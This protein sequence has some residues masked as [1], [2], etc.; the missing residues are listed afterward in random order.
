MK[1]YNLYIG[2]SQESFFEKYSGIFQPKGIFSRPL[3]VVVGNDYLG[4]WLKFKV[5]R[6]SGICANIDF[7]SP[8][9]AIRTI[10]G[11]VP[12]LKNACDLSRF[13]FKDELVYL[14]YNKLKN[15]LNKTIS[16]EK[17]A[18]FSLIL[19]YIRGDEKEKQA[20]TDNGKS[21]LDRL[22][23]TSKN[24]GYL[25]Y[26]YGQNYPNL[27]EKWKNN[28][29]CTQDADD[30][31]GENW[32]KHLW[33]SIYLKDGRYST[34]SDILQGVRSAGL[35]EA[36]LP[37][38]C[39]YGTAFLSVNQMNF[40]YEIS[41]FAGVE[42][43][44]LDTVGLINEKKG[45][46]RE[47]NTDNIFDLRSSL[48]K[49]PLDHLKYIYKNFTDSSG[50]LDIN[51]IKC[52]KNNFPDTILGRLQSSII[53]PSAN[54]A[55]SCINFGA[56]KK[57]GLN[58]AAAIV[59][60]SMATDKTIGFFSCTGK[61]RE[62][63]VLKNQILQMLDNDK[64]LWL[65]EIAIMAPDIQEY[66]DLLETTF[67]KGSDGYNLPLN[68]I[69]LKYEGESPFFQ[70]VEALLELAGR[71]FQRDEIFT[72]LS[73]PCVA[74]KFS[75]TKN[76]LQFWLEGIS[77]LN[78]KW[79]M[80]D[81]HREELKKGRGNQAGFEQGFERILSGMA[82]LNEKNTEIFS[83]NSKTILPHTDHEKGHGKQWGRFIYILRSLYSDIYP[84]AKVRLPVCRW[85]LLLEHIIN[86]YIKE[87][88]D[89]L[90]DQG[91]RKLLENFFSNI[92][93]MVKKSKNKDQ[94]VDFYTMRSLVF[95]QLG[96]QAGKRGKFLTDGIC[97]SSIKSS[98]N[99]PFKV[100]CLLGMNEGSFPRGKSYSSFDLTRYLESHPDELTTSP[101]NSDRFSIMEIIF[102]AAE[103]LQ[104]YYTG[105]DNIKNEILQPSIIVTEIKKYIDFCGLQGA[106]EVSANL[107]QEHPLQSFDKKYFSGTSG[108]F[109]YNRQSMEAARAYYT[110]GKTADVFKQSDKIKEYIYDL[111]ILDK[112]VE[113]PVVDLKSIISFLSNPAKEYLQETAGLFLSEQESVLD[114]IYEDASMDLFYKG[115][116][117][118]HLYADSDI[119]PVKAMGDFK[120]ITAGAS[121]LPEDIRGDVELEHFSNGILWLTLLQK[122]FQIKLNLKSQSRVK[123]KK[124]SGLGQRGQSYP[125]I[126]LNLDPGKCRLTGEIDNL[127]GGSTLL[128]YTYSKLDKNSLYPFFENY[129]KILLLYAGLPEN[130]LSDYPVMENKGDNF[131]ILLYKVDEVSPP[132]LLSY[133]PA[134]IPFL[135]E[136]Q[137]EEI[138]K[139]NTDSLEEMILCRGV[140]TS[141]AEAVLILAEILK[142]K[143]SNQIRFEPFKI[144]AMEKLLYP[145][146][147]D[148]LDKD[149]KND[150]KI[151][152]VQDFDE[153]FF[154]GNYDADIWTKYLYTQPVNFHQEHFFK[155][156][157]YIFKP[158]F[159]I[160]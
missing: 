111:S 119:N 45:C 61:F 57:S 148:G 93:K 145:P 124:K 96:G 76:D 70:G 141:K 37:G 116:I 81:S 56:S 110:S 105:K 67:S 117:Y 88:E 68:I 44:M 149:K 75:I 21:F 140:S 120:K 102:A 55:A 82:F 41:R 151:K 4:K 30:D 34:F 98:R 16:C 53:F 31:Y 144:K 87:R 71:A 51:L 156:A 118:Q 7:L 39:I 25:L 54:G 22:Y 58:A 112:S 1:K 9:N 137:W 101:L 50:N 157:N 38:I 15:M 36:S 147:W 130:R 107:T 155:T 29:N 123:F 12:E 152:M 108:Y 83:L 91:D 136:K 43:F 103:K 48:G 104:I 11:S 127:F 59:S 154:N 160:G 17:D 10:I 32:Q 100:I 89:N 80:D 142:M 35:P 95:Q 28:Q 131:K 72:L 42:H 159:N 3:I 52:Y 150:K 77:E 153:I 62:V 125:A 132:D 113:I 97:C 99:I 122:Y 2:N 64:S 134:E 138:F 20:E 106:G 114:D 60:S 139:A 8:D 84:L 86:F 18:E 66:A 26:N 109:S 13:L 133:S 128:S 23:D 90:R 33:E 135:T 126:E 49:L 65:T 79:G 19:N 78:M 14:V 115:G 121:A 74:Q 158:F 92:T 5:A 69:D 85:V 73:N 47:Q 129:L 143:F 146:D 94:V 6:I 63:S 24:I 46:P 40:F 27:I